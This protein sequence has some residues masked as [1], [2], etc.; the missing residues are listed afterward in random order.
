MV[1]QDFNKEVLQGVTHPCVA[2]NIHSSAPPFQ[3]GGHGL[4]RFL[5]GDWGGCST[6]LDKHQFDLIL[7]AETIY[8]PKSV[9]DL[10]ELL[11]WCLNPDRGVALVASKVYYFGVG[12]GVGPF[13]E[14]VKMQGT[15]SFHSLVN[16]QQDGN[17]LTI[18]PLFCFLD[19][20]L[21]V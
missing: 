4:A 1:F 7:T 18:S 12:G 6:F 13:E 21:L 11:T 5:S 14:A 3:G 16:T 19:G 8:E 10:L 15:Y 17:E 2:K 20:G 9:P